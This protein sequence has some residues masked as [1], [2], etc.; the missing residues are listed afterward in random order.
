MNESG[1]MLTGWLWLNN[2]WYYTDPSGAMLTGWQYINGKWYYL[3]PG[4]GAMYANT[5]TPDGYQVDASG[6]RIG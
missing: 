5:I 2:V 3:D 4:N 1:A 6:A